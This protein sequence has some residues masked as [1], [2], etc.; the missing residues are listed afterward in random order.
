MIWKILWGILF[1]SNSITFT[2]IAF[3][4]FVPTPKEIGA[5]A[6]FGAASA[7]L[8]ILNQD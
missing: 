4:G 5:A 7:C 3:F 6:F 8:A 2:A 1:I